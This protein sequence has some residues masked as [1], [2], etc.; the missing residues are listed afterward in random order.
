MASFPNGNTI[1]NIVAGS[2]LSSSQYKALTLASD[3]AVDVSG[4]DAEVIG[5]CMNSPS[6]GQVAEIATVGGGAKA[7][8][9]GTILAGALLATD[10]NGDVVT[11]TENQAVCAMA[12]EGAVDNDVFAVLP[13][14]V[15]SGDKTV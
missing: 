13:M 5:F 3:G 15:F 8:A 9:G 6:T 7:I 2:D 12:L 1:V 11:A 4:A 14:I 10:A